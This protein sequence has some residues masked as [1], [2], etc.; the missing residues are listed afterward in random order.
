MSLV[1]TM[2]KVH[3]YVLKLEDE[4]YYV[5]RTTDPEFRISQH[6]NSSGSQWTKKYK[7][8]KILEIIE[9]CDNFDE[10]KYTLKYMSQYGINNVRG[11]TFC[12]LK[13]SKDKLDT[14]KKMIVSSTDK[15]YVCGKNDH[16]A[17]DCYQDDAVSGNLF[18]DIDLCNRCHRKGHC[19]A[20][21]YAKTT[22]TG[23]KIEMFCC[24]Y[25]GK[26]IDT[27]KN[28]IYHEN[29][30]CKNKNDEEDSSED[31]SEDL[32]EDSSDDEI[33][34]F[35]CRYCGREF[36]TSKGVSCHEN[37]YCKNKK[38]GIKQKKSCQKS[39]YRCG[40]GGHYS[41]DCY[42]SKHINGKYLS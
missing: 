21:C 25:C 36:D 33:E 20:E 31:S 28:A 6:F 41:T 29:S 42:A 18:I 5:G 39:C 40:R 2:S 35:C 24:N 27:L 15:C 14:I 3:I 37:L 34:V 23:D 38:N 19:T 11:G 8:Q 1:I 30:L 16:F 10:D 17:K 7:P 22:I 13:L 9:D 4:K 26:E 12:E 32:S